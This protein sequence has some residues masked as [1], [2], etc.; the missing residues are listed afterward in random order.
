MYTAQVANWAAHGRPVSRCRG[1]T[2]TDRP[3]D[4][5]T[6]SGRSSWKRPWRFDDVVR[7]GFARGVRRLAD[8]PT[9]ARPRASGRDRAQ[10]FRH[11]TDPPVRDHLPASG[12]WLPDGDRGAGA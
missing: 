4:P 7:I 2:T 11:R 5:P 6:G 8:R 3:D 1:V 12:P 9:E 10:L